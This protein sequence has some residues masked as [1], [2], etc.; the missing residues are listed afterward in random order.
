VTLVLALS[1]GGVAMASIPDANRVI[2]GCYHSSGAHILQVV[3]SQCPSGTTVLNWNQ[4]GRTGPTGATG[5]TGPTGA[6]GRTGA[7]GPTGPVG[8]AGPAGVSKSYASV[9]YA[10]YDMPS[11]GWI[12][13]AQ[14]V[15]VDAGSYIVTGATTV[16]PDSGDE[17]DCAIGADSGPGAYYADA[18]LDQSSP[19]TSFPLSVTSRFTFQVGNHFHLWC[20]S[21]QG[22]TSSY[23]RLTSLTAIKIK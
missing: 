4:R 15:P 14:S 10:T 3:D 20:K 5:A 11:S 13:V 1:I 8:P 18:A 22:D 19:P 9:D 6:T 2:H 7:T 12:S 21:S 23:A 17:V 16:T